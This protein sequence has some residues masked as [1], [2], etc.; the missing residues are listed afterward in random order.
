MLYS[1]LLLGLQAATIGRQRG[2]QKTWVITDLNSQHVP[3]LTASPAFWPPSPRSPLFLSRFPA[4]A[5][6]GHSLPTPSWQGHGMGPGE[7]GERSGA[8]PHS[9]KKCKIGTL[10]RNLTCHF[11]SNCV[12]LRSEVRNPQ[13]PRDIRR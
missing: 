5:C 10:I 1:V 13:F 12:L 4:R 9:A 2:Q 6:M 8:G 11:T 7:A 3:L